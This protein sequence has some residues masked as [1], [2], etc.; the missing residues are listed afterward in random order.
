MCPSASPLPWCTSP[1][2]LS[3]SPSSSSWSCSGCPTVTS[4]AGQLCVQENEMRESIHLTAPTQTKLNQSVLFISMR[5]MDASQQEIES[6]SQSL[7]LET[8][9][10]WDPKYFHFA[11]KCVQH[12]LIMEGRRE[13]IFLKNYWL[14]NYWFDIFSSLKNDNS[15]QYLLLIDFD[16]WFESFKSDWLKLL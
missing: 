14:Y 4:S 6:Y 10:S 1:P 9:R 5:Q 7:A 13:K 15:T 2:G 8:L 16:F 3:S 12:Q 11:L